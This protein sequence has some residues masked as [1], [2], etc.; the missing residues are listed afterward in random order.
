MIAPPRSPR[1]RRRSLSVPQSALTYILGSVILA[2][3]R[4]SR[5][6]DRVGRTSDA[7]KPL[8][9]LG[10]R[11]ST[12]RYTRTLFTRPLREAADAAQKA[13]QNN[14]G[15][16]YQLY[17]ARGAAR[18]TWTARRGQSRS[19]TSSGITAHVPIRSALF[20]RGCAPTLASSLRRGAPRRRP[21]GVA[22]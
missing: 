20:R 18:E 2:F 7:P 14:P 15:L 10:F 3:R 19:G 5:A 6:R 8:R 21:T 11:R 17:A 9:S 1:L 12:I 22:V 13:V 4:R 16:S